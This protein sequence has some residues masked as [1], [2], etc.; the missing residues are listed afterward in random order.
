MVRQS[1]QTVRKARCSS[2][3]PVSVNGSH[4]DRIH[5]VNRPTR[6]RTPIRKRPSNRTNPRRQR[7]PQTR[8][9]GLARS[10]VATSNSPEKPISRDTNAPPN[11]IL[12]PD[13]TCPFNYRDTHIQTHYTVLALSVTPGSLVFVASSFCLVHEADDTLD[14][15][16]PQTPKVEVSACVMPL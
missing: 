3:T 6:R 10:T 15:R 7:N 4:S 11:S 12:Y 1:K 13:C 14:R 8:P 5:R 2:R 9:Y 16:P